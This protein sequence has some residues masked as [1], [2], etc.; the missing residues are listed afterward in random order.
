MPTC[1]RVSRRPCCCR[2]PTQRI[3]VARDQGRAP[4]RD[5]EGRQ[6]GR[7]ET[8][9]GPTFC[10]DGRWAFL[11]VASTAQPPLGAMTSGRPPG[12]P[13]SPGRNGRPGPRRFAVLSHALT[14]APSQFGR[15]IWSALNLRLRVPCRQSASKTVTLANSSS[16]CCACPGLPASAGAHTPFITSVARPGPG[17]SSP[18]PAA[19]LAI[20]VSPRCAWGS[21]CT[22]QDAGGGENGFHESTGPLAPA[23]SHR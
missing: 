7:Q 15:R 2:R 19:A 12:L 8:G 6:T 13:L 5:A 17:R 21:G 4:A 11:D 1:I 20:V 14:H 23:R 16:D 10:L 22:Y 18:I 9:A 3:A